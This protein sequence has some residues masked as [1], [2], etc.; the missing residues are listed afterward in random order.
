MVRVAKAFRGTRTSC[1]RLDAAG[2]AEAER[3]THAEAPLELDPSLRRRG[4]SRRGL[5][6]G[7]CPR[8]RDRRRGRAT[9]EASSPLAM[10]GDVLDG[11]SIAIAG[12]RTVIRHK[13]H[14]LLWRWQALDDARA[15]EE[16]IPIERRDAAH[17][18]NG[19]PNRDLILGL[20][21]VLEAGDLLVR[22]PPHLGDSARGS[23]APRRRPRRRARG[24]VARAAR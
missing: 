24:G 1:V 23:N 17:P 22:G 8:A 19:V 3:H 12:R 15:L 11:V 2:Q 9:A 18:G 5:P 20:A 7:P 4:D 16:S 13:C 21:K 14:S 10:R 6:L